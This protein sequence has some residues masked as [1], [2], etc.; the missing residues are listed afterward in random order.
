[1]L[2]RQLCS[3]DPIETRGNLDLAIDS[4]VFDSRKA[5]PG[6]LFVAIPGNSVDGGSFIKDAVSR[7]AVAVVTEESGLGELS[8][9]VMQVLDSRRALSRIAKVFYGNPSSQVVLIGI[10]GTKGKTTTTYLAQSILKRQFGK[11][12]RFGTIE[13]DL[14]ETRIP[15]KNTTPESLELVSLISQALESGM[16]AGIMEVSSHALKTWRVEDLSFAA[17]GFSNLS[18][19]HSE[20]HPTMEDY[21]QAKRRLFVDLLPRDK[22]AIISIDDDFG[23]RLV[24]DGKEAGATIRTLS[25]SDPA[26]DIHAEKIV[27]D[28]A[29]AEFE[30]VAEGTRIPAKTSLIGGFNICNALMAAALCRSVGASWD[31]IAEGISDIKTVPGRFETVPNERK[32][33]VIVDYAHSPAALEN[34]LKAAR[35][36]VK[37]RLITVFG[38]GG[39]RS[40]EKRPIM[41]RLSATLSDVTVVTSDNPRKEKPL[42]IISEISRGMAELASDKK[43]EVFV[44][45][46]RRKAIGMAISMAKPGDLVLIAGKGHEPGQ[47][48]ADRTIPFDDRKVAREFLK[49]ENGENGSH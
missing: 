29:G 12:F 41:G 25:L 39:N 38:C 43:G 34:V 48:F 4:V 44:E 46:D 23:R 47:T 28:F 30:I 49:G 18:F 36:L 21:F 16:K 45:E 15:A 35:P 7:G 6:S 27:P 11:A 31:Q 37:G 42:D 32:L 33:T 17:A 22:T 26:A 9:P 2:L 19:E 20:F 24:I 14:G 3:I 1:M 13:N 5:R 8:V 10:T 40:H